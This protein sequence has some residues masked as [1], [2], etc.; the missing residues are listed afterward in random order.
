MKHFVLKASVMGVALACSGMA[1]AINLDTPEL[2]RTYASELLGCSTIIDDAYLNPTHKMGF[3]VSNGDHRYLRYDLFNATF[4]RKIV[5]DDLAIVDGGGTLTENTAVVQGGQAGDDYVIFEITALNPDGNKILATQLV[6]FNFAGCGLDSTG[7]LDVDDRTKPVSIAYALYENALD[8]NRSDARPTAA[9]S[10]PAA[11][12]LYYLGKPGLLAQFNTGLYLTT[13]SGRNRST[14]IDVGHPSLGR[15]FTTSWEPGANEGYV[16]TR[17]AVMGLVDLGVTQN[18]YDLCGNI[19]TIDDFETITTTVTGT[20]FRAATEVPEGSPAGQ[21]PIDLANGGWNMMPIPGA[22]FIA[23]DDETCAEDNGTI[24][25]EVQ[26]DQTSAIFDVT[27]TLTNRPFCFRANGNNEIKAQTFNVE[28]KAC[29]D[30]IPTGGKLGDFTYKGMRLKAP[31]LNAYGAGFITAVQL[32]NMSSIDA[33][34]TVLCY[35]PENLS[36]PSPQ[37]GITGTILANRTEIFAV[38]Q[39][40]CPTTGLNAVEFI[41]NAPLGAVN[42]VMMSRD[43]TSGGSAYYDL[44]GNSIDKDH[45]S[46]IN[47]PE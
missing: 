40:G 24:Y 8:A 27:E 7:G 44:T 47:A 6:N 29:G 23:S 16:N 36:T 25:G 4:E 38:S 17:E 42:G 26:T 31:L 21:W 46:F 13:G 3:G 28:A 45:Y 43:K 9:G 22:V 1:Q 35:Y 10:K 39:L 2:P 5:G 19:A 15:T 37:Q 14:M 11:P 33:P 30:T 41:V 18:R 12:H 34:F 20:S 32:A